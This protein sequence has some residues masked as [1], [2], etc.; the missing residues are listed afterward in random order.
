MAGAKLLADEAAIKNA[1]TAIQ[2]HGG[3][4]YTWEVPLHL[5]LKRSRVLAT[6]FGAS[7][8][9]SSLLGALIHPPAA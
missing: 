9:L 5:H 2:V 4:G 1:R 3:M 8:E 7:A 6:T